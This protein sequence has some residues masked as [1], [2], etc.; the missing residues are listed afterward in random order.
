MLEW[1]DL[2]HPES[3]DGGAAPAR[4]PVRRRPV[5]ARDDA[6]GQTSARGSTCSKEWATA[7]LL[8]TVGRREADGGRGYSGEV[9]AAVSAMVGERRAEALMVAYVMR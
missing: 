8:D 6:E 3:G 9:A 1:V 2:I 5:G 4:A 7:E